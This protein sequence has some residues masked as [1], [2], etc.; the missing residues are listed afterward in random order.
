MTFHSSLHS[1]LT[2]TVLKFKRIQKLDVK[3]Y[4]PVII[5]DAEKYNL[6]VPTMCRI[7]F[8]NTI[9]KFLRIAPCFGLDYVSAPQYY[10]LTRLRPNFQQIRCSTAPKWDKCPE[11]QVF[12]YHNDED[13]PGPICWTKIQYLPKGNVHKVLNLCIWS[14][15][16]L[17]FYRYWCRKSCDKVEIVC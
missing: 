3:I 5:T 13:G 10:N 17:E 1:H 16:G 2:I 15:P 4:V 7:P 14:Y 9:Y 12:H 6:K 8:M 11:S